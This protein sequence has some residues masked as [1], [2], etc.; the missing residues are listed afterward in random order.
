MGLNDIVI[1]SL[2]QAQE[3]ISFASKSI[4]YLQKNYRI[5]I[6]DLSKSIHPNKFSGDEFGPEVKLN[7]AGKNVYL[8]AVPTNPANYKHH[9]K[10]DGILG[11]VVI[12]AYTAKEH[13]AKTVTVVAPD[14]YF[15]RADKGPEDI[16]SDAS[17]E[18]KRAFSEKGK[19]AEAQAVAWKASGVDRV[20]TL[21]VHSDRVAE[22][23]A[24]VY[25]RSDALIDL[26]PN[27]L[28]LDYLINYSLVDLQN[29]G[30]N[31]VI[32]R[33]DLGA[34]THVTDLYKSLHH[35]G[36][37]KVSRIDCEKIRRVQN[38]PNRVEV[39]NP[40]CSTNFTG[41]EGK[42]AG[43]LDDIDDTWGT[44]AAAAKLITVDGISVNGMG[45]QR[46]KQL[47]SYAT[48]PVLSGIEFESSMRRA[49]SISPLE[50][51]YMNTHPFIEDNMIFE[52]RRRT[53]IIRTAWFLGEVIRCIESGIPI[54]ESYTTDGKIDLAKIKQFAAQ[55]YRRTER[56]DYQDEMKR[57]LGNHK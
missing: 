9:V 7:L 27:P 19:S 29:Q 48:H 10:P 16:P 1:A 23:Y 55:P 40:T 14:L 41:L 35:L 2:T 50:I 20:I 38:D 17:G 52:L 30:E 56:K 6:P 24:K 45:V 25:G 26:N 4:E 18:K 8:F 15:S 39:V 47:F 57:I 43:L 11:R 22:S 54:E 33:A 21:H 42:T 5:H 32:I 49:A 34:E 44:K 53:S 13:G 51:I 3:S 28:L 36:Y 12:E 37:T 31:L 46:P